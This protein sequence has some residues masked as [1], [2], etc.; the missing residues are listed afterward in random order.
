MPAAK[1]HFMNRL[2]LF[3]FLLSIFLLS[4]TGNVLAAQPCKT[5]QNDGRPSIGLAL[6][7]GGARGAAHVGVIRVLEELNI[8]IDCISGTSMGSIIGGL[9]ASGMTVDEL[10]E[11]L[12]NIDWNDAFK[13]D[14][15]REDRPF[16]RKLE[17][18]EFLVQSAPGIS[19]RGEIKFPSGLVQGQKL[20]LILKQLTLPVAEI[21]DFDLLSIPFHAVATDIVTGHEVVLASGNLAKAMRAS[22]SVPSAFSAVEIDGK[23]LVD[24]GMANNLP[25]SV[26]REMGA[27]IVIAVDIS[28]PLYNRDE[29]KNILSITAQLSG[30]LTVSNTERSLASLT[31]MDFLIAPNLGDITSADFHRSTEAIL[32][33][34]TAT[35]KKASQ[36]R[37]LSLPHKQ[38]TSHVA[39]RKQ[40]SLTLPTIDFVR[41]DNQSQISDDL[42]KS[43]LHIEIGQPLDVPSLERDI[44]YIYGSS[45]YENVSYEIVEENGK[46]G[47]IITAE[48]KSWGPDYLQGGLALQGNFSGGNNFTV[49]TAYTK[50]AI[51]PLGGEWRTILQI[52]SEAR[53]FTELFQPLDINSRWF[54]NPIFEWKSENINLFDNGN[55]LAEYEV[56]QLGVGLEAGRELGYWGEVRG[57]YR[58]AK[59]D[60]ELVIGDPS[61]KRGD[62]NKGEVFLRLSVDTF[63]NAFFPRE[64]SVGMIDYIASRKDLG[65]DSNY[66]QLLTNYLKAFPLGARNTLLLGA[67]F[68][69]TLNSNAPPESLFRSGGFLRMS[70]LEE[71]ELTGQHIGI[72]KGVY[73]R[74]INDFNLLPTYVGASLEFGNAWNDSSDIKVSTLLTSGSLF[75]GV[76]T[77][78]GPAYFGLGYTEEGHQTGFFYLGNPF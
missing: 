48:E 53:F 73:L 69:T 71:D 32:T 35:E 58:R 40:R 9:Y 57:G 76:D 22:M 77:P 28:T 70:G 41:I 8:P 31:E 21:G 51:N 43:Q 47:I 44:G 78:I 13:D 6:S 10:E 16:R 38:F 39:A 23:L 37:L 5:S 19:N 67:T 27:D 33:G 42:I 34:K 1:D 64:G 17:D 36:L 29:I 45:L 12:L 54:I 24:G 63:D 7:G 56:P 65:A 46:E 2:F 72:I 15:N 3:T 11:A 61:L 74:K 52:G 68:D 55:K 4:E 66:D 50:T 75:L 60:A 14:S 62:F 49:A 25:V 18:Y 30:F 26:V 20:G 59:G